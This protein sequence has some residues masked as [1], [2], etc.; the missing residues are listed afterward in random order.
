MDM[1]ERFAGIDWGSR[2]HQVCVVD[3]KGGVLA[4]RAFDHG[5]AG[6]AEMA[7]WILAGA[8]AEPRAVGIA[9][10][11]PHGPVVETLME[12]GFPV[13]AV[14][15]KRLDRFRDRFSPAGAK[16]DRR[17]ARVL[18]N[19]LR[20]DGQAFR[21]LDP[22]APEIVELRAWSRIASR[23]TR[24]RTRCMNQARQQ[25]WRHCP[26]FCEVGS[27]LSKAWVRELW[28]LAPTPAKARRVRVS[29]VAALL[30]RHRVRRIDAETVL[31]ILREPAISVAPG[32][33]EAAVAHVGVVFSQLAFLEQQL[34]KAHREL[35]RLTAALSLPAAS[36]EEKPGTGPQ[37]DAEIPV[38]LPGVGRIVLATLP[39]EAHDPLRRRACH[40]L[41]CLSGV[42]PVTRRSGK[43][44]V[45]AGRLAAHN[46]LRDAVHHWA[47]VAMQ[48]DPV[49]KAKQSALRARGHGHARAAKRRRPPAR[50]RLHDAGKPDPLRSG[51]REPVPCSLTPRPH[52]PRTART[53][54]RSG[55]FQHGGESASAACRAG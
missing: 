17:D 53:R 34:A 23:L 43:S 37:R 39:A 8:D 33:T 7:A 11:I 44:L 30:K 16:D 29:T 26:K 2:T 15:P 10:E 25:F 6:L 18:A 13:H 42:A 35:A 48:R 36:A 51:H 55:P 9:I 1:L 45:V 27:D 54:A 50:R 22:E 46:R 41:R 47:A 24:D 14:N 12:R 38:S 52:T 28:R 31:R 40:A 4:E 32:T 19:A 49:S 20:T 3:N 5:G 21:H